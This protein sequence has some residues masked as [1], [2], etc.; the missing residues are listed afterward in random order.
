M[1]IRYREKDVNDF[2]SLEFL[3]FNNVP[4]EEVIS[5]ASIKEKVLNNELG[6][7]RM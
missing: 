5:F 2:F 4:I 6:M 7:P 1:Y 3:K